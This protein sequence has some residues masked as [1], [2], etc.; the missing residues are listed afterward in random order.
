MTFSTSTDKEDK[1]EYLMHFYKQ[2]DRGLNEIL[3][4]KTEPVVPVG[5]EYG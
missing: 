5:V 4:G 3:R 1:D 2:I